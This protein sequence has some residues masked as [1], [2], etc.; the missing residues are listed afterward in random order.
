MNNNKKTKIL[1]MD[2]DVDAAVLIQKMLG[3]IK[4]SKFDLVC[5][6]RLKLGLKRILNDRFDVILMDLTLPDSQ[7]LETL[8]K[9]KFHAKHLREENSGYALV[10][11]CAVQLT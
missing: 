4:E 5:V 3:G 7:G 10:K 11:G 8:T 1:F 6:D 9:T 2:A